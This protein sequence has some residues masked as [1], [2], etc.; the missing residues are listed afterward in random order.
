[1]SNS[2]ML[3]VDGEN[4]TIRGQEFAK[5]NNIMITS[6]PCYEPDVF[7]W[8]PFTQRSTPRHAGIARTTINNFHVDSQDIITGYAKRAH[9]FTTCPG[10]QQKQD[11]VRERLRG[12]YFEPWVYHKTKGARAKVV[13]IAMT[14]EILANA[15]RKTFDVLVLNRATRMARH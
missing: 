6:G 2:W 12:N 1:M 13:D 3:F 15:F 10:D 7:L 5:A 14:T 9:Y 11:D 4:F 8:L